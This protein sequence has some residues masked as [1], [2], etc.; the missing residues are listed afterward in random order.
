MNLRQELTFS[1]LIYPMH[2][3]RQAQY[4]RW[5]FMQLIQDLATVCN[6]IESLGIFVARG[7]VP[8]SSTVAAYRA[9]HA[10]FSAPTDLN[11]ASFRQ[12]PSS[13]AVTF[14]TYVL[15]QAQNERWEYM[16]PIQD[17]AT[18]CNRTE[19]LGIFVARGLVPRSSTVAAYRARRTLQSLGC[20]QSSIAMRTSCARG[21]IWAGRTK[22][23]P[24]ATSTVPTCDR[25]SRRKNHARCTL[26]FIRRA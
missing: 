24:P 15:R 11:Q 7:L 9:H 10:K 1:A 17:L 6:R 5:E 19:S 3:L 4:E 21:T 16:Q 8:R 18:V 22:R 12:C 2:V 25:H 20:A 26:S 14:P 23:S 13:P